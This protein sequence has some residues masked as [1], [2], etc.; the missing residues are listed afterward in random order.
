M[1]ELI[2][3]VLRDPQKV[4]MIAGVVSLILGISLVF[5][6]K[7]SKRLLDE[8]WAVD[9]YDSKELRRMCSGGF[10]AV[11]E[12]EGQVSCDEPLTSPSAKFPCC[13]YHV[14]VKHR[15]TDSDNKSKHE[16]RTIVDRTASTIFKINDSTGYTFVDPTNATIDTRETM[17]TTTTWREPWFNTG[18]IDTGEYH[19]VEEVFLPDGYAY[20]LGQASATGDGTSP[21]VLIHQPARGYMDPKKKFFIISRENE[22][23]LTESGGINASLCLWLSVFAFA[24]TAYCA[25]SLAGVL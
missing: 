5:Y 2:Q 14:T 3:S 16:W 17:N 10:D 7:W 13:W 12:V 8:M 19:I 21:H 24:L 9:M 18:A 22:K 4:T 20:V 23:D 11:V 15:E 25:L 6:Y 1:D